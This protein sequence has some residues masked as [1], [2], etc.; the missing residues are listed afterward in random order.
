[1]LIAQ[2]ILEVL[3]ESFDRNRTRSLPSNVGIMTIDKS[4]NV[5]VVLHSK[6]MDRTTV[7]KEMLKL[8]TVFDSCHGNTTGMVLRVEIFLLLSIL[9]VCCLALSS[10]IFL[11][12]NENFISD[13][14][15]LHLQ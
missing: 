5:G 4:N 13:S 10:V 15:T 1:M 8:M 7:V 6:T 9:R 14:V 11:H 3:G 12:Y 2:S